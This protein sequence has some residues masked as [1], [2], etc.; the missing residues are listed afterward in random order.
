M[1]VVSSKVR[2]R[3]MSGIHGRNTHPEMV[4]RRYLHA[5]GLRYRLHKRS[6]P[7]TPDL[8]FRKFNTVIFVHGCFWHRHS[9]CR[10]ATTPDTNRDFWVAK[11]SKN[12]VRDKRDVEKLLEIGWRVIIIWECGLKHL[13]INRRLDWLRKSITAGKKPLI[14][15]PRSGAKP[16]AA[17]RGAG[18]EN[19]ADKPYLPNQR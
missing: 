17:K 1:D 3:M 9:N 5:L 16:P 13:D 4:I 7:G 8:V 6:L 2:S 12:V 11:L 10:F 19:R 18:R 14:E 15:W